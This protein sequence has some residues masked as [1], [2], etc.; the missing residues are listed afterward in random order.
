M[1]TVKAK[2]ALVLWEGD[3][4][5]HCW[6]VIDT[7]DIKC[8]DEENLIIEEKTYDAVWDPNEETSPAT[9]LKLGGKLNSCN[10]YNISV[11]QYD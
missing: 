11:L 9:V 5:P 3:P 2:Y 7:K 1:S 4:K 6:Q 8:S 10:N